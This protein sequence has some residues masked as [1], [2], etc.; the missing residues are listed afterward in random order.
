MTQGIKKFLAC[1][2]QAKN[3]QVIDLEECCAKFSKSVEGVRP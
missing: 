3:L 1:E 2:K